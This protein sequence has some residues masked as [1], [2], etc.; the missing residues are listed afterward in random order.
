MNKPLNAYDEKLKYH[1]DIR[2]KSNLYES[3]VSHA[4]QQHKLFFVGC[5]PGAY[6]DVIY[7]SAGADFWLT[8]ALVYNVYT[9]VTMRKIGHIKRQLKFLV[10]VGQW[11]T[12]PQ[13]EQ[14][15]EASLAGP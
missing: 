9:C 10:R 8:S 3:L 5:Q 2:W 4:G 7:N 14:F 15:Q 1:H 11:H 12:V 6:F 13:S